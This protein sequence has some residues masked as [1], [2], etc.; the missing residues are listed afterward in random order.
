[1]RGVLLVPQ[2]GEVMRREARD[3]VAAQ[4]V[5]RRED[6]EAALELVEAHALVAVDEDAWLER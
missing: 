1:M 6:V 3:R 4:L 5:V 2:A